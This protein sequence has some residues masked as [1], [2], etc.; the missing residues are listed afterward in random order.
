MEEQQKTIEEE[1]KRKADEE[2]N[3]KAM[4][5]E[6][7]KALYNSCIEAGSD[8]KRCAE[9]VAGLMPTPATMGAPPATSITELVTA[10]KALDD[11]RGSDKGLAELKQ[12]FDSLAAEIRKGNTSQ[13]PLD[14]VAFAK[15][16]AEVVAAWHKVLQELTPSAV[17]ASTG[18][19]LD[20]VQ[21]RNRHDE[22]MEGL[23]TEKE[24]KEKLGDTLADL[25]ERVGRGLG[26]Q[27]M[28]GEG[29]KGGGSG[30]RGGGGGGLDIIDCECGRKIRVAP[31]ADSVTCECGIIYNKTG[32]VET[33]QE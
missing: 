28:E 7:A 33:R 24:Y 23:K 9:M 32:T 16:Q 10:L 21:E 25:P 19:P 18:D 3:E 27:I 12:G 26:G 2:L 1:R 22:A 11:L 30:G 29:S 20:V 17:A 4:R 15:Q 5:I 31:G 6:Q 8:P 13:Q 14:P